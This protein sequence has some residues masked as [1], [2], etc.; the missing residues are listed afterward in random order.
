MLRIP[1]CL[2]SRLTDGGKFAS[3]THRPRSTPQKRYCYASGTHFC[4]RLSEPQGLV[5]PERLGPRKISKFIT[6]INF[7]QLWSWRIITYH[8]WNFGGFQSY[9]IT[10]R[11]SIESWPQECLGYWE[12]SDE[13]KYFFI[14]RPCQYFPFPE[15]VSY[16]VLF[17]KI[18]SIQY[19][20]S[21]KADKPV[22]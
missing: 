18:V 14:Q 6:S 3:P 7:S 1:H 15:D 13:H 21:I 9:C 11:I 5:R 10:L 8:F 16:A 20:N 4:Y 22:F 12:Q 2:D 17:G 19:L